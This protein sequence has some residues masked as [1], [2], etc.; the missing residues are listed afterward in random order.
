MEAI[1]SKQEIKTEVNFAYGCV[2]LTTG[3]DLDEDIYDNFDSPVPKA[4]PEQLALPQHTPGLEKTTFDFDT[5]ESNRESVLG[6]IKPSFNE[7]T[8]QVCNK[9]DRAEEVVSDYDD[10]IAT[11]NRRVSSFTAT[12]IEHLISM[13]KITHSS[14]CETMKH[15]QK[16]GSEDSEIYLPLCP[17]PE[18]PQQYYCYIDYLD[19]ATGGRENLQEDKAK[20]SKTLPYESSKT[21]VPHYVNY[22]EVCDNGREIS[23]VLS[24][25]ESSSAASPHTAAQAVRYSCEVT[26]GSARKHTSLSLPRSHSHDS[27]IDAASWSAKKRFKHP[28]PAPRPSI[29]L[30]PILES[31]LQIPDTQSNRRQTLSMY[32][33][34]EFMLPVEYYFLFTIQ[35]RS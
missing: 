21:Q 2:P 30:K 18:S 33:L 3:P 5:M 14:S 6:L 12:Q 26:N 27:L 13:L 11:L 10:T 16:V 8:T 28:M 32:A 19:V 34:F 29:S 9:D 4:T 17:L 24:E 20:E 31:H 15:T 7:H 1:H 25:N 35:R 22:Q 23:R